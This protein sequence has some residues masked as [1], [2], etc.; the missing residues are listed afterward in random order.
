MIYGVQLGETKRRFRSAT[1]RGWSVQQ[2]AHTDQFD[3]RMENIPQTGERLPPTAADGH[4]DNTDHASGVG[5]EVTFCTSM[6]SGFS[7]QDLA[8]EEEGRLAKIRGD[9]PVCPPAQLAT[10]A[11]RSHKRGGGGPRCPNNEP[12][13]N[14]RNGVF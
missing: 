4:D 12:V 7:C 1:Q 14:R 11:G 8:T 6:F 3:F 13:G 2:R 5:S 9:V 10:M